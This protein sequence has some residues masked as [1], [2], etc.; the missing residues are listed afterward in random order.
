[1][2]KGIYFG[3]GSVAHKVKKIYFGVNGVARKVKKIYMGIDGKARLCWSA[4]APP[5]QVT[6]TSSQNWTVPEDVYDI[7]VFLVGGGG[8]SYANSW[9]SCGGYTKTQEM[10]VAPGQV[11]PVVIGAGGSGK[12]STPGGASSFGTVS[13]NGGDGGLRNAHGGSGGGSPGNAYWVEAGNGG[14]DGG[15]GG[16]RERPFGDGVVD[17]A[18]IDF[19]KGQGTTTRAFG[20]PTG[21]L[22]AG[23]GGGTGYSYN[24]NSS[25]Y[26]NGRGDAGAGGGGH[27]GMVNTYDSSWHQDGDPGTP[28]T[29]GGGGGGVSTGSTAYG[30]SGIV[31]V[32]WM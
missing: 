7:Q 29:G 4:S 26:Y 22:Y 9:G 23:G 31:I 18:D 6:F 2:A 13:V 20:E 21:T 14:S 16:R 30:G 28:N 8:Y 3:Y 11:I 19:G 1:M 15:D 32:R 12:R 25:S 24:G 5:G 27:G 17:D 10:T